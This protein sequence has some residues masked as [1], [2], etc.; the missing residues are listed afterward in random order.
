MSHWKCPVQVAG[1]SPQMGVRTSE[2]LTTTRFDNGEVQ[3]IPLRDVMRGLFNRSAA[4]SKKMSEGPDMRTQHI[5]YGLT[6]DKVTPSNRDKKISKIEIVKTSE[7]DLECTQQSQCKTASDD[8]ERSSEDKKNPK[9]QGWV[10]R[11]SHDF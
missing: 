9:D 8:Y 5:T 7:G 3:R 6:S 11:C 10:W 1:P 4:K 2:D